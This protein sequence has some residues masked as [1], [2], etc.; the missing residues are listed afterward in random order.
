[1]CEDDEQRADHAAQMEIIPPR[2]HR[3]VQCPQAPLHRSLMPLA[4]TIGIASTFFR[5]ATPHRAAAAFVDI[6]GRSIE[7]PPG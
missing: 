4:R 3:L 1:M 6:P 7:D 2:L 5:Q